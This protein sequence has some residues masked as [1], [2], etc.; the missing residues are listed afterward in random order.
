MPRHATSGKRWATP[1]G[2]IGLL[3]LWLTGCAH[4]VAWRGAPASMNGSGGSAELLFDSQPVQA[5][6]ATQPSSP[7][8]ELA[9]NDH[10]WGTLAEPT[11]AQVASYG[12]AAPCLD[13]VRRLTIQFRP[14]TLTYFRVG[15]VRARTPP[16]D[17]R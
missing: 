1:I 4:P 8:W 9:R 14:E 6:A 10:L 7:R 17:P 11:Q 16:C 13:D 2:A 12:D 5:A 15:A 3:S